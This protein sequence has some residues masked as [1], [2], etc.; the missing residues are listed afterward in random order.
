MNKKVL[1]ISILFLVWFLTSLGIG[2]D[3]ILPSPLV[4]G[5]R[6]IE[7]MQTS[8][9]Y[10]NIS[11]TFLRAHFAFGLS[12]VIGIGLALVCFRWKKVEEIIGIWIKGL[13]TIPQIS[14]IIFLFFWLSNEW[15]V[16][17]VIIL[18][19]FPITYFNYLESLNNI[20]REYMDII[21]L[22]NHSWWDLV[23]M[24]YLPL[25]HTS[26]ASSIKSG[27]PL[28]LKVCVMSE[29]LIYT[30][31]GIGKQLSLAKMGLDMV[32]VFTW[33]LALI[34]LISLEMKGINYLLKRYEEA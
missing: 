23:R 7:L 31:V 25:C 26:F 5:G 29:V 20:P 13:Q 18:M 16:Y 34:V 15:C 4:V 32:S 19:A 12:L 17:V 6:L 14:F 2:N 21:A 24:V 9:F 22:T 1:S 33:T 3:V 8:T 11:T 28:S 27:L 10:L 30:S